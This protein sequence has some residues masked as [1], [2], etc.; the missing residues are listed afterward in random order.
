MHVDV[1]ADVV[2]CVASFAEV[3]DIA[4][5][6]CEKG[7]CEM[8]IPS[9]MFGFMQNSRVMALAPMQP[10]IGTLDMIKSWLSCSLY[11]FSD[12]QGRMEHTGAIVLTDRHLIMSSLK[13]RLPL[14]TLAAGRVS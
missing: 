9:F 1:C 10:H 5:K 2:R 6:G 4:P 13:V 8:N 14:S 3:E 12:L 11:Y 7:K